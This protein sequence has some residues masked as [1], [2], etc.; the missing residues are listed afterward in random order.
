MYDGA[1][2]P[3]LLIA[4]SDLSELHVWNMSEHGGAAPPI[5]TLSGHGKSA[6]ESN[7]A[8]DSSKEKPCVLSGDKDGL[9]CAYTQLLLAMLCAC[10]VRHSHTNNLDDVVAGFC[11]CRPY[12]SS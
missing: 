7:F 8:L 12:H 1:Q 2:A 4:K 10:H 11:P 3:N 9:I 6:C 5:A